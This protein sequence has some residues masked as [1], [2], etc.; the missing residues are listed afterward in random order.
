MLGTAKITKGGPGMLREIL[1]QNFLLL[2]LDTLRLSEL[3]PVTDILF[4]RSL[5]RPN[6]QSALR[7]EKNS[8]T[9]HLYGTVS[10]VELLRREL[11]RGSA[12]NNGNLYATG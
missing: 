8:R 1:G 5:W 11:K 6:E 2:K 3:I 12:W 4:P 7:K 9:I 10:S